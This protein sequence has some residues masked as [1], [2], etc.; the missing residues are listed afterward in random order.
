MSSPVRVLSFTASAASGQCSRRGNA[1]AA[2]GL[3]K[4]WEQMLNIMSYQDSIL[5]SGRILADRFAENGAVIIF[6]GEENCRTSV[7]L[8]ILFM[9]Y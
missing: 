1:A 2:V 9:A 5:Y 4:R 7:Q 6:M 8:H 3:T